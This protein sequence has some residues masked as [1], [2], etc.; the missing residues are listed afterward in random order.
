MSFGGS[1]Y[2]NQLQTPTVNGYTFAN[3]ES[4]IDKTMLR[5][6]MWKTTLRISI[7]P[8][9]ESD[10]DEVKYDWKNGVSIF[11]VP[12]KAMMFAEI[13]KKY[14]EDPIGTSNNGVAS[15]Q[16]LISVVNPAD[17]GKPDAGPV[18]SIRKINE[19]G[20]VEL[21]YAY[22]LK[23]NFYNAVIGFDERSGSYKQNFENFNMLEL[24]MFIIQLEQY[25][26]AMSN[27]YAFASLQ[28]AYPIYDKIATKLG[29]D[30]N[31]NYNSGYANKSYFANSNQQQQNNDDIENTDLSSIMGSMK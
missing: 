22:E 1:V 8:L 28:Q 3:K 26:A 10:S 2:G 4:V 11:L 7:Y 12:A 21:S 16:G 14:K 30:L 17:Y 20:Q 23:H 29:V 19:K 24:D 31:S 25:C 15:G 6:S 5:F 13:L 27:A 9:I 18:I